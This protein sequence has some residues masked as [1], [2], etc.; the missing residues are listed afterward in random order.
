MFFD[1]NSSFKLINKDYSAP[2]MIRSAKTFDPALSSK[3][4]NPQLVRD[5]ALSLTQELYWNFSKG[6]FQINAD[7]IQ[8]VAGFLNSE[9]EGFKFRNL[10]VKSK[11]NYASVFISAID[12]EPLTNSSK[13][14]L[15]TSARIDNTGAKYSPSHTS[16]IYGGSS[17]ILIEPVYA[18]CKLALSRFKS[19]K[20]YTLDANNYKKEEYKN[21]STPDKNTLIITTDGNSKALGYYIEISR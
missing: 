1:K 19:I 21:F 20:I 13:I 2:L 14:L 6:I 15:N 17:P 12:N 8:G 7:K 18:V 4:F 10:R 16:V 11:N 9:K 3:K 5:A